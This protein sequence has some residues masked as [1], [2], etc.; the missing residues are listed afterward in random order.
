MRPP[1]K[2]TSPRV[3]FSSAI[4]VRILAIDGTWSRDC[5]MLD[6]ANEGAKLLLQQSVGGL[7]LKEFLLA[8]STTGSSF[9]HCELAWLNGNEIGVRF[10]QK[11]TNVSKPR[12]IA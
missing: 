4:P 10:V 3:E 6:V 5:L 2:R 8:L 12:T 1:D 9:R 11:K 7:N